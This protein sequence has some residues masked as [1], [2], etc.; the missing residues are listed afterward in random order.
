MSPVWMIEG[1]AARSGERRRSAATASA[2]R[3][4]PRRFAS[5]RA[6]PCA[7]AMSGRPQDLTLYRRLRRDLQRVSG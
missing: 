6:R 2:S 4:W 1:A 7:S 5:T 3:R